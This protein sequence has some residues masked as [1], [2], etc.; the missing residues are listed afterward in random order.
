MPQA[1]Y[2]VVNK[3][4]RKNLEEVYGRESMNCSISPVLCD[5][6]VHYSE[7]KVLNIFRYSYYIF[8]NAAKVC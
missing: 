5:I 4:S 1:S 8:L 3:D 6:Y 7:E 2:K